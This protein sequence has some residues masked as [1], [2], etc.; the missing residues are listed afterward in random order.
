MRVRSCGETAVI[1]GRHS[2]GQNAVGGAP[3]ERG[4]RAH[5]RGPRAHRAHRCRALHHRRVAT[6]TRRGSW[7]WRRDWL[8]AYADGVA[9][10]LRAASPPSTRAPSTSSRRTSSS[11]N[12]RIARVDGSER[13]LHI[14]QTYGVTAA[15][16]PSTPQY[17]ALGHVHEPQEILDAPRAHGVQRLAVTARLRR[18]RAAEARAHHR[19]RAWQAQ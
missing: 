1:G 8:S 11:T 2:R 10:I 17:I 9:E 4:R 16:L 3:P 12:A 13:K 15:S 6:W 18:A 19:R 5:H 7:G 14:G